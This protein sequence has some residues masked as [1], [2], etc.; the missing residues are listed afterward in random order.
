MARRVRVLTTC[1]GLYA[2][3]QHHSPLFH[4]VRLRLRRRGGGGSGE[5]RASLERWLRRHAGAIRELV[6]DEPLDAR[7]VP[8]PAKPF[9]VPAFFLP[10]D[11]GRPAWSVLQALVGSTALASLTW[12]LR[13]VEESFRQGQTLGH[14]HLGNVRLPRL[15]R[16]A[17][18]QS[19][20]SSG[21]ALVIAPSFACQRALR[22]LVVTGDWRCY[23]ERRCLPP[24]LTQLQ[25]DVAAHG[26]ST[27]LHSPLSRASR[28]RRLRLPRAEGE[29]LGGL[30]R[31]TALTHLTLEAEVCCL[32]PPHEVSHP[33]QPAGPHPGWG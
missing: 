19:A 28:L 31:L 7:R 10:A 14:L 22:S 23:L 17:L 25:L 1:R 29:V 2:L 30:Q 8:A 24:G 9:A 11:L 15:R 6:L 5:G 16:L 26:G 32:A 12:R 13:P 27:Q 3:A 21:M 20:I 33:R 4:S 18:Q